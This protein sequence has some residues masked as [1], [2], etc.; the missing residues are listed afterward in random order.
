MASRDHLEN[1]ILLPP[2][3]RSCQSPTAAHGCAVGGGL[4]QEGERQG[5][6]S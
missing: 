1:L 3:T 2:C 5:L 4:V 6:G